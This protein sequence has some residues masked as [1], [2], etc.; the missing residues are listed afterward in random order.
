MAGRGSGE[1]EA[2]QRGSGQDEAG[3]RCLVAT[4]PATDGSCEIPRP[5]STQS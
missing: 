3:R 5:L 4:P 1:D 2:G